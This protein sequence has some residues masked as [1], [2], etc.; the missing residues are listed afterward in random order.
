ME[1]E[2]YELKSMLMGAASQGALKALISIGAISP[3]LS[4]RE[5]YRVYGEGVVKRWIEE[6]LL[7]V[8]KDGNNTSKCRISRL[9][10]E[11]LSIANNRISYLTTAERHNKKQHGT[12]SITNGRLVRIKQIRDRHSDRNG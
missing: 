4:K 9:E 5:A 11:A 3:T 10:I 8:R 12:R 2:L 1:L 7:T 6:G